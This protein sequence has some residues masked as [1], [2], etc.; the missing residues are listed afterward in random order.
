MVIA[1]IADRGEDLRKQLVQAFQRGT[2]DPNGKTHIIAHSQG[3]LAARYMLSPASF[4]Y[5]TAYE[6]IVDRVSSI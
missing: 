5:L 6:A 3:G 4:D 1:S 2:F